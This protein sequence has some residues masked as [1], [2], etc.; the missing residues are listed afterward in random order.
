MIRIRHALCAFATTTALTA[1]AMA[2]DYVSVDLGFGP[3][4]KPNYFGA[5]DYKWV[6]TGHFSFNTA[7]V[8]GI[9][10][11]N[12]NASSGKGKWGLRG[13]FRLIGARKSDDYAE[14]T[15]LEDIDPA[16]E[17]GLGYGYKSPNFQ[18]FGVV[19]QGIGGHTGQVAEFGA[20]A[21]FSVGDDLRVSIGPRVLY[22]SGEYLDTYFGV[23]S[24][25]AAA[26]S[27]TAYSPDPGLVSAGLRLDATYD[28]NN[29]WGIRAVI[30]HDVLQDNA[31]NSPIVQKE[32]QSSAAIILTREFTFKF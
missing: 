11:G 3:K 8:R 30:R 7:N 12:P 22:G 18:V 24:A 23:S 31:A 17:L 26:S 20:D 29:T 15:G 16:I 21:K 25:E 2:Q 6:P 5:E 9:Q 13:S 1:P 27:F 32:D 28:I 4:I 14:L 10:I 19:R